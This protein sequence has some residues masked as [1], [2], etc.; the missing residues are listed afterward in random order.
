MVNCDS[1]CSVGYLNDPF[2]LA[3]C[4]FQP[5]PTDPHRILVVLRVNL[6]QG[7]LHELTV[8]YGADYWMEYYHLLS[9]TTLVFPQLGIYLLS[10]PS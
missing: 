4:F 7:Q 5:D 1:D 2:R 10:P 3:N 6:R 9:A 8:N